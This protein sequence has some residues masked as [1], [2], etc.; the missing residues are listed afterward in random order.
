VSIAGAQ[1][2][3]DVELGGVMGAP[4]LSAF[5]VT[6]GDD[7]RYIWMEPD[8]SMAIG[9]REPPPPAPGAPATPPAKPA[10]SGAAPAQPAPPPG[11]GK[12]ASGNAAPPTA[13]TPPV[14]K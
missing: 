12:P 6:F 14:K 3:I 7:G 4:L 8:P 2:G 1:Q 9:G 5:R 13:P 11:A 10:P